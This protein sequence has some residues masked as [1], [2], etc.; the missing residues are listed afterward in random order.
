MQH[1]LLE[2]THTIHA[3]I[4]ASPYASVDAIGSMQKYKSAF[5]VCVY[6]LVKVGLSKLQRVEQSV[7]GCQFDIVARLLFPHALDDSSQYLICTF[8][9]MLWFLNTN[10]HYTTVLFWNS[11]S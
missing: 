9:E 6:L 8:L 11:G 4:K 5:S 1:H 3:S 2:E 10:T 7:G